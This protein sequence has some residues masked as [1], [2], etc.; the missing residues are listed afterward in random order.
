MSCLISGHSSSFC[1]QRGPCPPPCGGASQDRRGSGVQRD[2]RQ[3]AELTHLHLTHH[4]WGCGPQ[5]WGAQEGRPA[6]LSQWSGE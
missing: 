4:P 3:G 2:G 5:A 1:S 6:A